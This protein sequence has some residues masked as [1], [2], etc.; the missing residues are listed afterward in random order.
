[1]MDLTQFPIDLRRERLET[2]G[3]RDL[4]I[5]VLGGSTT[6]ELVDLWELQLL[7]EGFRPVFH[8]TE[9]GRYHT[10]AV[11]S[12]EELIAFAPELIYVHTSVRNIEQFP[13][14]AA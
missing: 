6:S 1:M 4:R 8:Q 11:H 3:L 2:A 14:V 5:A 12:P 7:N 10:D 13:S 9:Y